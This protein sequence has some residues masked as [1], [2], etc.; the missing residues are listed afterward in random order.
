MDRIEGEAMGRCYQEKPVLLSGTFSRFRRLRRHPVLRDLLS[1]SPV[2]PSDL[3]MPF[4]VHHHNESEPIDSMPGCSR[5]SLDDLSLQCD[6]GARLGVNAFMLFGIP[7]CKDLRGLIACDEDGI[8]QQAL[9]RLKQDHPDALFIADLCFCEY[10]THGHCGVLNQDSIWSGDVDNDATLLLLQQQA[11]SL[12]E[13]GA[14]VIA[15]S[16]MM[17]GMVLM[18][19]QALDAAGF[20]DLPILSYAIKFASSCYGPFRDAADSGMV[21]GDRQGY[22]MDYRSGAQALAEADADVAEGA[23]MLMV[24]PAQ[25]YLD[26]ITRVKQRHG[27]IPLAAYQ[28]SGEYSMICSAFQQGFARKDALIHESLCAIKRAGA[29]FIIS[30]F[31]YDYAQQWKQ[32]YGY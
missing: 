7:D 4:F 11:I 18:I 26:V 25:Y 31:A 13:A 16:G 19:R 32:E 2:L 24:K 1:E 29:D 28:V 8:M 6:R 30:Y 10:T 9:R 21:S 27:Q 22:Q 17:D 3:V 5:L 12:A 15:P 20:S 14:D 23:D